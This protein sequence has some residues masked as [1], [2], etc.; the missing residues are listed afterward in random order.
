MIGKGIVRFHAVYWLALLL[1]AGLPLPTTVFVHEYLTV[2]GAKI[3]KS[4][5]QRV[6]PVDLTRA[7]RHRR[8]ALVAGPRSRRQQPTP[9]SP[10]PG[11]ST[12]RTGSWPTAWATW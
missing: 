2:D 12:G 5:G 4:S 9:T 1:S 7:L 3:S 8:A 10:Q 11:W 6:D